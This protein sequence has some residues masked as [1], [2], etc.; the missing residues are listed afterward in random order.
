[1]AFNI[2]TNTYNGE[3]SKEFYSAALHQ[4]GTITG[5]HVTILP[6]VK[7]KIALRKADVGSILQPDGCDF[8]ASGDIILDER[9]LE[10]T[11]M[12]LNM[13]V[14]V[15]DLENTWVSRNMSAGSDATI[16]ASENAMFLDLM[17]KSV[18]NQLEKLF[19]AGD[20]AGAAPI[21]LMDGLLKIAGADLGTAKVP[22]PIAITSANVLAELARGYNLIPDGILMSSNLRLYVSTSVFRAYTEAMNAIGGSNVYNIQAGFNQVFYKGIEVLPAQGMGTASRYVFAE[23]TNIAF[24]TD[25]VSDITDVRV[26]NMSETTGANKVRFVARMKAGVQYGVSSEIVIY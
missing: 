9:T 15:T 8:V 21:N 11:P 22:A 1:M 19:W 12:M 7:S 10:V 14:C 26:I 3:A 6:N 23:K 16:P 18:G 2:V 20:T 17:A 4:S 24:G 25:L 5:G 13:E